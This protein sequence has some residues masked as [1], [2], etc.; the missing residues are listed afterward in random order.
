MASHRLG[1]A[2]R[3]FLAALA[4]VVFGN[5]FTPERAALIVRLAPDAPGDLTSD[6]EALARVVAPRLQALL[7]EGAQA[8]ERLNAEDR[9]VVEPALLYICYHRFVPQIDARLWL[10]FH[11]THAPHH[12]TRTTAY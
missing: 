10:P 3:E 4:D 6:R 8:I 1:T 11:K 7:R 5:P 2:D 9:R 12:L